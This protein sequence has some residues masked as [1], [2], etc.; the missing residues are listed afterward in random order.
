MET[1]LETHLNSVQ[2][3]HCG[4]PGGDPGADPPAAS[5]LECLTS[6]ILLIPSL[7]TMILALML[8]PALIITAAAEPAPTR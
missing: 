6:N 8:I 3:Y 5:G 4:Y 7:A 1:N 2:N